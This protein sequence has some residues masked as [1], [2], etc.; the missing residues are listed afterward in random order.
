M[1]GKHGW[2]IA[3]YLACCGNH[4]KSGQRVHGCTNAKGERLVRV[5]KLRDGAGK[6]VARL[7]RDDHGWIR[8]VVTVEDTRPGLFIVWEPAAQAVDDSRFPTV[9]AIAKKAVESWEGGR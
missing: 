1:G 9:H 4:H 5:E 3:K 8:S 6:V 2:I 7:Y